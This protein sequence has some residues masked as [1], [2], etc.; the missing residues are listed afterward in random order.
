MA[1]TNEE[2]L[3]QICSINGEGI[4]EELMKYLLPHPNINT[5][6]PTTFDDLAETEADDEESELC[7]QTLTPNVNENNFLETLINEIQVRPC[8]WQVNS[9]QYKMG[10]KRKQAWIDISQKL[11][12]EGIYIYFIL[13]LGCIFM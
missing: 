3:K 12:R 8:I 5:T 6:S 2:L 7:S 9:A 4:T 13:K 10:H 1:G 11:N